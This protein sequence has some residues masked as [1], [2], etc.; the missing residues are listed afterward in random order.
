MGCGTF[1]V[2]VDQRRV[3]DLPPGSREEIKQN[4]NSDKVLELLI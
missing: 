1:W 4:S 2:L 3:S